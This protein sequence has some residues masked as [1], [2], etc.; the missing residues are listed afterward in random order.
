MEFITC[1]LCGNRVQQSNGIDI[2]GMCVKSKGDRVK[3]LAI[4]RYLEIHP[5][6]NA[7]QVIKDLAVTQRDI[8]RLVR[9]GS[10]R[11]VYSKEG[12]KVVNAK[13]ENE[14]RKKES[15]KEQKKNT[16]SDLAKLYNKYSNDDRE[17]SKEKDNSKLLTDLSKRYSRN[18]DITR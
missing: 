6:A 8:D 2:C 18:D 16:L 14:N 3:I 4:K 17:N 11:L 7:Q 13:T 15:E 12:N 1:S 10:L 9:D 5:N